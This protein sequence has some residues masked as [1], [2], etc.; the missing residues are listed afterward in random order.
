MW[1]Q[2]ILVHGEAALQAIAAT[3]SDPWER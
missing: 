3:D 1:R 2:V